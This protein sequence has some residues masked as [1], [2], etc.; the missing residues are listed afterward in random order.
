[1]VREEVKFQIPDH[2]R[3]QMFAWM[4]RTAT[5]VSVPGIIGLIQLYS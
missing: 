4:P 3:F 1:M 5:L 2:S